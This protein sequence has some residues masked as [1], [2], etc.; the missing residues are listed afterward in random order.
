M[1]CANQPANA[2][3]LPMR[4]TLIDLV[5]THAPDEGIFDT[6]IPGVQFLRANSPGLCAAAVY[7]PAIYLLVQGEKT[8][9]LGDSEIYYRPLTYMITAVDL[10]VSGTVT[11][12]SED[13]PFLAVKMTVDPRE[14]ADLVLKMGD[15]LVIKKSACPCGLS[16]AP[17]DYGILDTMTRLVMLLDTPEHAPV[18]VPLIKR[19]II[20]RALVGEMGAQMRNFVKP[21]SHAH[22]ITRVID[23]IK[24]RYKEPLRVAE[25]AEA[26][27][28]SESTLYHAFKEVTR[29]SPVQYQ[30]KLRLHEARKLM[31][32][33]GL[34]ASTASYKVGYESP[35]H[36]SREYSRMFGAPPRAD[37]EK[38]RRSDRSLTAAAS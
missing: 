35:S 2:S 10:P 34:E 31:L 12:A 22:R 14:V 29:M 3:S 13:K 6:A 20:Y 18:L 5:K 26:V 23:Q 30:K 28:M 37:V 21:D 38:L 32:I 8:V 11:G 15:D 24:Q 19:E 1:N 36:F 16:A 27:N 9:T 4:S 25:L 33:E 7:E 17:V